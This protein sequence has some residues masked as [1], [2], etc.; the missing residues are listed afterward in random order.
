[1]AP[2]STY[3][4]NSNEEQPD[5]R[6]RRKSN[7]LNPEVPSQR[8]SPQAE[9]KKNSNKCQEVQDKSALTLEEQSAKNAACCL[10]TIKQQ[11]AA[12]LKEELAAT[13]K[14]V[15]KSSSPPTALT[16]YQSC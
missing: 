1:M 6:S 9:A 5:K 14:R 3:V 16:N 2:A 12:L 4:A 13:I 7:R 15:Q 8:P 10:L 11:Q